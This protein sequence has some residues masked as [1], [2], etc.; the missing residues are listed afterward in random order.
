MANVSGEWLDREARQKRIDLLEATDAKL[1][2]LRKAGELRPSQLKTLVAGKKELIRLKRIHRAEYDVLYFTYEYF[3]EEGNPGNPSNL[4]PE[5]QKY[6]DA[7]DFHSELCSLLD[8]VTRKE[9]QS[10]IG[11]SVGRR[12]AKTAYLSNAFLC[13]QIAFR[14]KRYIV[15]VSETT[16]V[17]GDFVT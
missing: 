16:D 10:N 9:T 3:S 6:G 17:A 2:K 13:Q 14:L 4:I 15:Q 1:E 5:G 11:W 7:A 8:D 12:H